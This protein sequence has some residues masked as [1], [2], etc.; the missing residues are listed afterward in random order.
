MT[1]RDNWYFAN[2]SIFSTMVKRRV[3]LQRRNSL[4]RCGAPELEEAR[5]LHARAQFCCKMWG[6]SLVRNQF[7]AKPKETNVG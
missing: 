4:L 7:I 1:A 6:D 5:G 2:V 3:A